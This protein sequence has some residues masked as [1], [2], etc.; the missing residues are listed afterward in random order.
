M[1]RHGEVAIPSDS[2]H[3]DYAGTNFD[4]YGMRSDKE[5]GTACQTE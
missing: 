3:S 2:F 5:Y 1:N 4:P